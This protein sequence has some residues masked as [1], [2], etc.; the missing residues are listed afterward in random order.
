M[1]FLF[2]L[3]CWMTSVLAQD[4]KSMLQACKKADFKSC[5]KL[6]AFYVSKES[7]SHAFLIGEM[8]CGKD[9]VM[10]CTFAGTSLLAQKKTKEGLSLLNKSCDRFEPYAC[11]S[12]GRLMKGNGEKLLSYMYFKRACQYGQGEACRSLQLPK[13]TYSKHGLE[14]LKKIYEKC[15]DTAMSACQEQL[16]LVG[17]CSA[18]LTKDDCALMPGD[19]SIYFR[20]KL[21]QTEAALSLTTIIA[22]QKVLKA[23][24]EHQSYSYDLAEVL[25]TFKPLARYHYVF[26]FMKACR[27]K[28]GKRK[29]KTNSLELFP[30][31][32]QHLSSRVKAN[33]TEY[34][35]KGKGEECYDPKGGFQ[36]FAVGSLDALN[37]RKMDVWRSN[38][39]GNLIQLTDGL[40]KF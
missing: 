36:V 40:P 38:Q 25:K 7:W 26:G 3:L 14:L 2:L 34:F 23:S 29:W 10:G 37:P 15:V 12:L 6:A 39:D 22:T 20:A 9:I 27:N 28:Y 24:P 35:A 32:Y 8:L 11:R 19:L 18:P 16:T 4:E 33:I 17:A 1:K 31:A 30:E 5:E 13:M 21:M